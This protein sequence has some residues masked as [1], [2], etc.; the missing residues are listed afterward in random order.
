MHPLIHSHGQD[1]LETP[2]PLFYQGSGIEKWMQWLGKS[3]V[4]HIHTQRRLS[5]CHR[6]QQEPVLGDIITS[7]VMSSHPRWYHQSQVMSHNPGDV[8][9]VPDDIISLQ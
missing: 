1:N 7:Q 6:T 5:A 8:I 9:A 4:H 3:G 2:V